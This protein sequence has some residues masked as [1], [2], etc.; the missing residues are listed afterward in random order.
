MFYK[1]NQGLLWR[2]VLQQT[3]GGKTVNRWL[4]IALFWIMLILAFSSHADIYYYDD[5][6]GVRHFTDRCKN[7]RCVLFMRTSST[8]K[9]TSSS[10]VPAKFSL[11]GPN[12]IRGTGKL[13]GKPFKI[14]EVNRKRLAPHINRI[15]K[16]YHLDPNLI[17]A[18]ISAESAFN[19]SAVS[20]AGA[21]GLMQLMPDTA[22]RFGVNNPFDPVANLHGG[23]RYLRWLMDKFQNTYLALAA[24]NAGE[25]AVT[26][27]GNSIPPYEETQTYVNR[28]IRFYN[29]YRL[30][31]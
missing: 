21:M 14:N 11:S 31:N 5:S 26:R 7:P 28:V 25:G 16:K 12:Y 13:S 10:Y 22:R 29:Y 4:S 30:V 2:C 8:A 17:H 19:P 15:A 6:N 24:Y 27:Y 18:I 3:K 1:C 23:V 9:S 20:S